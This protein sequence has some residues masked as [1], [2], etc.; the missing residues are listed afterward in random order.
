MV[1]Y[2]PGDCFD[3]D[4]QRRPLGGWDVHGVMTQ[5]VRVETDVYVRK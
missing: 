5:R 4:A 1:V 3:E 2:E